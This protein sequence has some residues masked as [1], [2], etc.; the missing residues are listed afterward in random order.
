VYVPGA[1]PRFHAPD[2]LV[3]IAFAVVAVVVTLVAWAAFLTRST[4]DESMYAPA[5]SL[6]PSS[7]RSVAYTVPEANDDVLYVRGLGAN[8]R[9]RLLAAF[10]FAFN[11]HARGSVSPHGD[12]AAVLHVDNAAG[13]PAQLTLLTLPGGERLDVAAGFDYLSPLAWS[14]DGSRLAAVRTLATEGTGRTRSAVVEV[15]TATGAVAEIT[16][17]DAVLQ[18]VPVGYSID[19]QRLFVV[20]IDQSGS[21]LWVVRDGKA[22]RAAVLSPG[23]TRDWTLSPDGSRLAFVDRIG[24]GER[25]YAGRTLIVATGVVID[26]AALG[27]QLGVAW[28]PGSDI[29][30]FGGPGGTLSL[31]EPVPG[32]YVI[33]MRWAPDGSTLVATIYSASRDS[34]ESMESIELLSAGQRVRLSE[35][36]GAKF[37]GWARNMD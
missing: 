12:M 8:D 11:L 5:L 26:A 3:P 9:P 14:A 37:L 2:S 16:G 10:P 21:A 18:V 19:A 6:S 32:A 15:N 1:H 29:P 17:F 20:V 34:G 31:S 28:R 25:T 23:S 33:P 35:S 4:T 13:G 30:D 36:A 27:D 7:V 24:V 22:E